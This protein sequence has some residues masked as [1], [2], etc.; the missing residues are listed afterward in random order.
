MTTNSYT[1]WIEDGVTS[2]T[3]NVEVPTI[4]DNITTTPLY[5]EEEDTH[6]FNPNYINYSV[7]ETHTDTT[8][9][10]SG[11]IANLSGSTKSNSTKDIDITNITS[12][13][14]GEFKLTWEGFDE[15]Q[16]TSNNVE[17]QIN[18]YNYPFLYNTSYTDNSSPEI[19]YINSN[20]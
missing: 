15:A 12:R 7:T 3:I 14:Y 9:P 8:K 19:V 5:N 17:T 20:N 10:G 6:T 11:Q 1:T 18:V 2:V 16:N 4:V 13:G